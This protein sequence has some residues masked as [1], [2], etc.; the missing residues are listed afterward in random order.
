MN[1]KAFV[2]VLVC[3]VVAGLALAESQ[4]G[5]LKPKSVTAVCS[6]TSAQVSWEAVM[7]GNLTGYDVFK[8]TFSEPEYTKANPELVTQTQYIVSNLLGGTTYN[9][10]VTAVYNDG[11]SSDLS[12]PATCTTS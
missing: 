6:F 1:P 9:F 5:H 4:S 8:K 12:D 10:A 2:V 7:D 3:I 11:N